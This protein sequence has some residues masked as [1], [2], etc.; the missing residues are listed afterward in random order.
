MLLLTQKAD[1]SEFNNNLIY[2]GGTR[3]NRAYND[4]LA[5]ILILLLIIIVTIHISFTFFSIGYQL[6]ALVPAHTSASQLSH[7]SNQLFTSSLLR[8]TPCTEMEFLISELETISSPPKVSSKI[9]Y[10][11]ETSGS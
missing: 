3:T 1:L 5:Q 8:E 4:A 11:T 10:F 6:Q 9:P 2:I 7:I